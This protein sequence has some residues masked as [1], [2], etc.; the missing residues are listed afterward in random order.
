MDNSVKWSIRLIRPL[1]FLFALVV[2]TPLLGGAISFIKSDFGMRES[3]GIA[4][5]PQ[6]LQEAILQVYGADAYGWRGLFAIHTWFAV[7]KAGAANYTTYQVVGWRLNRGLPAL[8]VQEDIPDRYW[9]G[10]EPELLLEY[11]G[12][13]AGIMI[14]KLDKA[15]RSYPFPNEYT[16]WPGPNS[17]SFSAWIALEVP[18]LKLELPF[19]AIG[20]NWMLENYDSL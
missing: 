2:I 5:D 4:P 13:E 15:A 1:I 18:E 11:R 12:D 17:N 9:F 8:S 3:A 16:L 6:Q 10:S 19:K 14:E 7:K 20:K